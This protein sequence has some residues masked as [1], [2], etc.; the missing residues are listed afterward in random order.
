MREINKYESTSPI[1]IAICKI[2]AVDLAICFT[3]LTVY[4]IAVTVNKIDTI[5]KEEI[6][7]SKAELAEWIEGYD[8]VDVQYDAQYLEYTI[9]IVRMNNGI[10]ESKAFSTDCFQS[11]IDYESPDDKYHIMEYDGAYIVYEP[12]TYYNNLAKSKSHSN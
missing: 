1:V 9:T 5:N 12:T 10:E 8:I 7:Q 2:I 6:A 4:A 11:R 3:G